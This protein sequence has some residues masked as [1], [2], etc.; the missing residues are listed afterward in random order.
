M[1]VFVVIN[2]FGCICSGED[3]IENTGIRTLWVSSMIT[4]LLILILLVL[5]Q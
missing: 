2:W 3:A 4:F 5:L 1:V